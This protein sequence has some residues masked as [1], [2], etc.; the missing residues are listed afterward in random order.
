MRHL[1]SRL[2][3][4][5]PRELGVR[6]VLHEQVGAPGNMNCDGAEFILQVGSPSDSL[7]GSEQVSREGPLRSPRESGSRPVC[8]LCSVNV[9]PAPP[10]KPLWVLSSARLLPPL[11]EGGHGVASRLCG[12]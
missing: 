4:S 12:F 2:T 3:L 9:D 10:L 5:G 7:C 8:C 6:R 1:T 11:K